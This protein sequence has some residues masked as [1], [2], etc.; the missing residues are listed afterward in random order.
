[1]GK[2]TCPA[3]TSTSPA[4]KRRVK[5]KPGRRRFEGKALLEKL[6]LVIELAR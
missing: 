5:P 6:K 2:G 1:M 4:R 3:R